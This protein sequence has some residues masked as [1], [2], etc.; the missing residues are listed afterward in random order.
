MGILKTI[1]IDLAKKQDNIILAIAF[2]NIG[3]FLIHDRK[4]F[5]N[6]ENSWAEFLE[7]FEDIY[8]DLFEED[9]N[10]VLAKFEEIFN[11]VYEDIEKNFDE[12]EVI[13]IG[14]L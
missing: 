8:L 13:Y 12:L 11:V 4:Y 10:I 9:K 6:K 7:Y 2:R 14:E 3:M 5:E 1:N